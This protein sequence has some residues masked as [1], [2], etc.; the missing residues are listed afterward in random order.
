MKF[1]M[2]PEFERIAL[3]TTDVI[4]T[5]GGCDPQT[6]LTTANLVVDQDSKI[7]ESDINNLAN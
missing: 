5:S 4:V 3:D 7:Q 6:S 2:E 1:F